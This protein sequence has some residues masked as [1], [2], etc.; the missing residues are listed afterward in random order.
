MSI[1]E[2]MTFY[3]E[4]CGGNGGYK[5]LSIMKYSC[6]VFAVPIIWPWA[7]LVGIMVVV[8][9]V[10]ARMAC[11]LDRP[12]LYLSLWQWHEVDPL[13]CLC[14]DCDLW[15]HVGVTWKCYPVWA[16]PYYVSVFIT[17]ET[18]YIRAMDMQCDLIPDIENNDLFMKT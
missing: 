5:H 2:K 7:S 10:S 9:V 16:I 11:D 14:Q 15:Q 17:L 8:A 3:V 18:S 12:H 6:D 4:C 13:W 1:S